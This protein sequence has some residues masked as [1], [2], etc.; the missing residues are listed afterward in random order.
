MYSALI[1][2]LILL[3]TLISVRT[4]GLTNWIEPAL[5]LADIFMSF[6]FWKTGFL[7]CRYTVE[8]D[9]NSLADWKM[10]LR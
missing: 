8:A 1:E 10:A 6:P 4:E 7:V 9:A 2:V 5:Y 3:F